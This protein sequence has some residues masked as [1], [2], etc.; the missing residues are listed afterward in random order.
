MVVETEIDS[1]EHWVEIE[2]PIAAALRADCL[3]KYLDL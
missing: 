3:D 2:V 1:A